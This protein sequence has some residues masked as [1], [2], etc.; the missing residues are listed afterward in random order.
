MRASVEKVETICLKIITSLAASLSPRYQMANC[1]PMFLV[2]ILILYHS[3]SENTAETIE[4]PSKCESCVIFARDLQ[5]SANRIS[6]RSES[7]FIEL[8]ETFCASMLKYKVHK[9]RFGL[10]RFGTEE[11]DTMKAL[12]DL[13]NRGVEVNLGIPYEMWQR[14]S[15]EITILKQE[16]ERIL[17]L[18]EDFLEEWFL[19]ESNDPLEVLLCRKRILRTGEDDCLANDS[20]NHDL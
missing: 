9:D 11:T 7:S 8:M 12:N 10:S 1:N 13:R 2:V 18:N 3:S 16:C 14:P 6:H 17:A 5:A 15:A 19:T 4:A 20:P